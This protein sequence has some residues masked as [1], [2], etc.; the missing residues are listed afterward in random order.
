[1]MC[2]EYNYKYSITMVSDEKI[3]WK[4][5][6]VSEVYIQSGSAKREEV[7]EYLSYDQGDII[8]DLGGYIGLFL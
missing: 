8:G 7:L 4:N 1:M 5:D 2:K 3:H 6:W